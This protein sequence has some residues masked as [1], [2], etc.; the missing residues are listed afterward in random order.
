M[1]RRSDTTPPGE[2]TVGSLYCHFTAVHGEFDKR[3]TQIIGDLQGQLD[4][5]IEVQERERKDTERHLLAMIDALNR[6][7]DKAEVNVTHRLESLNKLRE[8]V[9]ADRS[10]FMTRQ[11]ISTEIK[12]METRIEQ[13]REDSFRRVGGE[14]SLDRRRSQFQPW[15]I[16]AAGATVF[17]LLAAVNVIVVLSSP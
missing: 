1:R 9:E 6:A 3:L 11:E 12:A 15:M 7:V 16:W 4:R 8:A 10:Q 17:V 14:Q 5:R 13:L 2:W